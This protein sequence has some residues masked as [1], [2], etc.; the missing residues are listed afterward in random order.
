M[1]LYD[2]MFT[3]N[4][5]LIT[6][7]RQ[8][9]P[10]PPDAVW[11]SCLKGH[12]HLALAFNKICLKCNYSFLNNEE[13]KNYNLRQLSITNKIACTSGILSK[14]VKEFAVQLIQTLASGIHT[15]HQHILYYQLSIPA[16]M[17][18]SG[19]NFSFYITQYF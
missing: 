13:A 5:A 2:V 9:V 16:K 10:P 4:N 17:Q 18:T 19:P 8:K 12:W 6:G 7:K 15:S 11:E 14:Y 3:L 1:G